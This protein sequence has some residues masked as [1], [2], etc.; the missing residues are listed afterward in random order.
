MNDRSLDL[1]IRQTLLM[2]RALSAQIPFEETCA[3][4]LQGFSQEMD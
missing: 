3:L 4:F 2:D 1:R